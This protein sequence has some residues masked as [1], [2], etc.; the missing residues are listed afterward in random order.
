MG[1][2]TE[3]EHADP[4]T[5]DVFQRTTTGLALYRRDINT[6]MFTNGRERWALTG[7]GVAHWSGWHGSAA[8]TGV[9]APS[10]VDEALQSPPAAGTYMAVEA[11]TIVDISNDTIVR[12]VVRRD[13]TPYLIETDSDCAGNRVS[14]GDVAFIISPNEF[15]GPDSH[16]ILTPG[17]GECPITNG[18]PL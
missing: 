14:A 5:G 8:P 10:L 17:G 1:D 2:P 11:V 6:A 9:A 3:C 4:I 12:L 7:D 15:A 18:R 16:L 13:A